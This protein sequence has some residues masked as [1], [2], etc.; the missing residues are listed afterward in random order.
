[1]HSKKSEGSQPSPKK[2]PVLKL[3]SCEFANIHA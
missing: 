3:M 1:M 2:K